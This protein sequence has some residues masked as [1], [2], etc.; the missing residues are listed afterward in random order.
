M[1]IY[2][3]DD[4][5]GNNNTTAIIRQSIIN[6]TFPQIA[7]FSGVYGTG[8]STSAEIVGLA[9]TCS[10]P[11]AGNPCL[12]CSNCK[13]TLQALQTTAVSPR[14]VKIN[15]GQKNTKADVDNMITDIF[16]FKA[17]EDKVIYIIE[18]AHALLR[19]QQ[20]ALLEELDKIPKGVHVIFCTTKVTNLIP[21]LRNRAIEFNFTRISDKESE[22]L[23]NAMCTKRAYPMDRETKQILIQYA[24][25]VPRQLT[26]LFNFVADNQYVKT[27]VAEFLGIVNEEE[28]IILFETMKGADTYSYVNMVQDCIKLH[29]LDTYIE[30]LK[31]FM[32]KILFL[33]DGDIAGTLTP[34]ETNRIRNIFM[35]VDYMKIALAI[36]N[37]NSNVSEAD[38]K[39][40]ML[41]IRQMFK[42][43]TLASVVKESP[44]EAV[45]QQNAAEHMSQEQRELQINTTN[46]AA[47]TGLNM[48]FLNQFGG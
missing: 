28:F 9:L 42:N 3:F 40:I 33:L 21:E 35:G 30:Q 32:I 8:K 48:A 12:A 23:L 18:E 37:I 10:N 17:S 4:L 5:V 45:K 27:T 46:K 7:I 20:T 39:F 22:T 14:V 25:G 43:K 31:E 47:L 6:G 36:S 16:V 29:T 34:V 38:F 19:N 41:K 2:K 44:I 11:Q 15:A 24:K 1:R 13:G 26:K